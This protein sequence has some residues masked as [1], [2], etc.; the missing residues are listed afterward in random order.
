MWDAIQ[1]QREDPSRIFANHRERAP[2]EDR[3]SIME[4]A[5]A[6]REGKVT[7]RPSWEDFGLAREVEVDVD[8]HE[9]GMVRAGD[10]KRPVEEVITPT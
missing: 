5:K 8:V 9:G 2:K 1:E 6:M 10:H 3:K 4:Q 7:W